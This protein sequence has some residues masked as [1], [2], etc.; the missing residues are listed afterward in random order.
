[1]S[2]NKQKKIVYFLLYIQ[3]L[4]GACTSVKEAG[5]AHIVR[6]ES[7]TF[8]YECTSVL[9]CFVKFQALVSLWCISICLPF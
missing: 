9:H 3:P 5:V 2:N 6:H 8:L 1:M 4:W 7:L